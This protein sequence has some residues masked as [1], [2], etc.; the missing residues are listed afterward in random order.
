MPREG[1]FNLEYENKALFN[2]SKSVDVMGFMAVGI[3]RSRGIWHEGG[4]PLPL[5]PPLVP[6]AGCMLTRASSGLQVEAG[7]TEKNGAL[8]HS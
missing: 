7:V 8:F 3:W 5:Q 2:S 4:L 1:K 6:Y